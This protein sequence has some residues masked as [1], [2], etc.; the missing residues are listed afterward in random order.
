M[1]P[2]RAW[3]ARGYVPLASRA[4]ERIGSL[5]WAFLHTGS[6]VVGNAIAMRATTKVLDRILHDRSRR[7]VNDLQPQPGPIPLLL[8]H[9]LDAELVILRKLLQIQ[10]FP[11]SYSDESPYS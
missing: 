5:L 10:R 8:V 7:L 1:S 9:A 6:P 11:Q 4:G 2:R 3:T